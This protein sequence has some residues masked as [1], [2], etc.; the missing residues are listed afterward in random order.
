MLAGVILIGRLFHEVRE[1]EAEL[2]RSEQR[3]KGLFNNAEISIWNEDFSEACKMLNKLHS[4]G[5][6]DLRQYLR[7]NEHV[8]WEMSRMVKVLHVND[9]TLNLFGAK[10]EEEI[11]YQIDKTSDQ[12][13]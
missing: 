11:L 4:S 5:I 13:R 1:T 8:A 9:A 12:M 10:T 2:Q 3:F 7:D 6:R